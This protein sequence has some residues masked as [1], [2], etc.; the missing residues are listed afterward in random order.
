MNRIALLLRNSIRY[1]TGSVV[2]GTDIL[3]IPGFVPL[4]VQT[5]PPAGRLKEVHLQSNLR[6][7]L[8]MDDVCRTEE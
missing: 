7:L 4:L 3:K 1:A 5:L 2:T 6:A 8:T